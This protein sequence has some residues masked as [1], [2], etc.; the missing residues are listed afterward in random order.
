MEANDCIRKELAPV[1]DVFFDNN[2]FLGV[3]D[4]PS[5][6]LYGGHPSSEG[7]KVWAEAICPSIKELVE[8]E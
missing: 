8:I 3:P 5:K 1:V 7:C 6:T 4:D 2:S